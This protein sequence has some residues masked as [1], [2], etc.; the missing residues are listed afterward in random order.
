MQDWSGENEKSTETRWCTSFDRPSTLCVTRKKR[1]RS[2]WADIYRRAVETQWCSHTKRKKSWQVQ[3]L[4]WPLSGKLWGEETGQNEK[5][6]IFAMVSK[7]QKRKRW[8]EMKERQKCSSLTSSRAQRSFLFCLFSLFLLFSNHKPCMLVKKRRRRKWP[9][10]LL[11]GLETWFPDTTSGNSSY[12]A[13]PFCVLSPWFHATDPMW[14][15]WKQN[16]EQKRN[17]H[18]Q[19]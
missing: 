4:G 19:I 7:R 5:K 8:E 14:Y 13:V 1:A 11:H 17:G 10:L 12:S 16:T 3:K 2:E 9:R 15:D 18:D 6:K